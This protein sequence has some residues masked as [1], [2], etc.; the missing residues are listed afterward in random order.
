MYPISKPAG[1]RGPLAGPVSSNAPS[2]K[3]APAVKPARMAV[4]CGAQRLPITALAVITSGSGVNSV[5]ACSAASR[6]GLW[7]RPES[8]P[9]ALRRR[10]RRLGPRAEAFGVEDGPDQLQWDGQD[11][12][13]VFLDAYLDQRLQEAQLQC[14][15]L[16]RDH[17]SRV[18]QRLRRLELAVGVD[19]LRPLL[20]LGLGLLGH[21]ALHGARQ[22]DV[23]DLDASHL[24]APWLGLVVDDLLQL[25]VD[26]VPLRQQLVN[27]GLAQHRPKRG[28]RDLGRCVDVVQDLNDRAL[29]VDHLEVD[30]GVDLGG[31]VVLGDDLLRR[32]LERDHAQVDLHEAVDT[33][34]D[35]EAQA[36]APDRDQAAKAEDDAA[37][38]LVDDPDARY[39]HDQGEQDDDPEDDEAAG[40]EHCYFSL[41]VV[42]GSTVAVSRGTT[43]RRSPV[44]PT[45]LTGVPAWIGSP[46]V[47]A[48]QSAPP[49]KTKKPKLIRPDSAISTGLTPSPTGPVLIRKAS[50]STS[51]TTPP[52]LRKPWVLALRSAT[53][54]PRA[55]M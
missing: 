18:G 51:A 34:R 2:R 14:A 17:L 35:D 15:L 37:L 20:A 55:T 38:V 31:H 40:V 48:F 9:S 36:R 39:E 26:D 16:R 21:G 8:P 11:D 3:V 23:L 25:L 53:K 6:N 12:R 45:T 22:L 29:R 30:D 41:C 1:L 47:V 50:Q 54:S 13:R 19:D 33:E 43:S 4:T 32:H 5:T 44:R 24:D 42:F 46:D 28:L 27:G 49:T 7:V 52:A 10:R